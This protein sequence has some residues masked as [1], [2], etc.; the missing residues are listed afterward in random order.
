LKFLLTFLYMVLVSSNVLSEEVKQA[1]QDEYILS[2][3][4]EP[5]YNV[6]FGVSSF[7]GILGIERQKGRHSVGLGFPFR[8]SYRY[9]KAPY[10]NSLFYGLYAG[11]SEQPD[12]VEKKLDGIIYDKEVTVD[13]G[14]GAGYRWQWP[15]SWNV[16]ASLSIH[17]MDSEYSNPG[18]PKEKDSSVILFPGILV[19]YKF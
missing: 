19:G 11:R 8:L 1:S 3:D 13:A 17:F 4:D 18:Q 10:R 7:D 9:Y 2:P 12:Q 15:S 14:F 5:F 6:S 16:T